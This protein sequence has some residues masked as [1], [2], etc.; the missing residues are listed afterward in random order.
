MSRTKKVLNPITGAESPVIDLAD[1]VEEIAEKLDSSIKETRRRLDSMEAAIEE[2]WKLVMGENRKSE[3][4]KVQRREEAISS[5]QIHQADDQEVQSIEATES[6]KGKM[7]E[8][9]DSNSVAESSIQEREA[10]N[11]MGSMSHVSNQIE[12][13]QH[14]V[15][16]SDLEPNCRVSNESR[17]VLVEFIYVFVKNNSLL[18]EVSGFIFDESRS[19]LGGVWLLSMLFGIVASELVMKVEFH[20]QSDFGMDASQS[21]FGIFRLKTTKRRTVTEDEEKHSH[22]GKIKD[23]VMQTKS[24]EL[25]DFI[26]DHGLQEDIVSILA[27]YPVIQPQQMETSTCEDRQMATWTCSNG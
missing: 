26:L 1:R 7:I 11:E 19:V 8:E 25:S 27:T 10:S 20:L 6:R 12:S 21:G 9:K 2:I 13:S 14:K 3:T 16:L 18:S 24:L 22:Y 4:L 17:D 5:V 15:C 23:N